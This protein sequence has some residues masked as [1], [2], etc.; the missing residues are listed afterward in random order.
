MSDADL[1]APPTDAVR[2]AQRKCDRFTWALAGSSGDNRSTRACGPTTVDI[3]HR[4][5]LWQTATAMLECRQRGSI[6]EYAYDCDDSG[7]HQGRDRD[8]R[9]QLEYSRPDL[10]AQAGVGRLVLVARHLP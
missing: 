6:G 4:L 3:F 5:A 2:P 7:H 9:H 10:C 1:Q 8:R